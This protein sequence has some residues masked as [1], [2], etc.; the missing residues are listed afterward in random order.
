MKLSN[1]L[2]GDHW[3]NVTIDTG[4]AGVKTAMVALEI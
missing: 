1:I 4:V 3:L 2:P